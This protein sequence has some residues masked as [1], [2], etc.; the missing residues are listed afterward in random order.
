[1]QMCC[2]RTI[3]SVDGR[4]GNEE[5]VRFFVIKFCVLGHTVN[6]LFRVQHRFILLCSVVITCNCMTRNL[7]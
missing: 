7:K 3:G 1:M 5:L 4:E 6:K 2:T